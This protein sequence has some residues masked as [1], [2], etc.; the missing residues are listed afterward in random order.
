MF[1]AGAVYSH[2]ATNPSGRSPAPRTRMSG[3]SSVHNGGTLGE[4]QT[5]RP[6]S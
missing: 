1:T 6:V 3:N 5:S 2:P 4:A